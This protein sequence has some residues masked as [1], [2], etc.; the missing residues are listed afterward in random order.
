MNTTADKITT[1]M[2]NV[3]K[4][5]EAGF[6][7]GKAEGG[8]SFYDVFWDN[9][10]QNGNRSEYSHAFGEG[11]NDENFKPKYNIV[12]KSQIPTYTGWIF[13]RSK[14]TNLKK[15]LENQSVVFDSG[16]AYGNALW[17]LV[18]DST[19]T[20]L[21]TIDATNCN[22]LYIFRSNALEY[23]EKFIATAESLQINE[24]NYPGLAFSCPKLKHIIIEGVLCRSVTASQPPLDLESAKSIINAL[25]IYTDT[26][27]EYSY[28]IT[29]S[30]TTWGY[31]DAEGE[32]ASPNGNS[33]REYINDLGWNAS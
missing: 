28:T 2:N 17:Y 27:E 23:V 7:A 25:K 12:Q 1:I 10:Q 19:I 9:F 20:H 11:F 29:F 3:P 6:E 32:T 16:G 4:V 30:T 24:K 33:W 15:L 22:M 31:L 13:G 14:I 18:R 26:E 21:P 5:Y 8:D